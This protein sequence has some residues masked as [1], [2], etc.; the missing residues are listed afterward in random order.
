MSNDG[1]KLGDDDIAR[2]QAALGELNSIITKFNDAEKY[3]DMDL[4]EQGLLFYLVLRMAAL[5]DQESGEEFFTDELITALVKSAV[6]E[7]KALLKSARDS[8]QLPNHVKILTPR[9]IQ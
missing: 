2:E 4:I 9:I 3:P 5:A 1:K 6:E 7:A 8:G